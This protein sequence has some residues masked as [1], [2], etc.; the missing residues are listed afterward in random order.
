MNTIARGGLLF[1]ITALITLSALVVPACYTFEYDS[2]ESTAPVVTITLPAPGAEVQNDVRF[3]AVAV[4]RDGTL[5]SDEIIWIE[6][7]LP[8]KVGSDVTHTMP[9]GPHTVIARVSDGAGQIG[10]A[11]ISFEVIE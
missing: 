3:V 11:S 7:D 10:E 6:N 8:F 5:L 1:A 4:D 9:L 2:G